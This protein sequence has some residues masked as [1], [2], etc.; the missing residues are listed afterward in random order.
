MN[1]FLSQ[2]S[3][4]VSAMRILIVEDNPTDRDLLKYL[5]E[6]RFQN[7]AKFREANNLETAFRYLDG[8]NI[9]CVILDLQLPDSTGKETFQRL[10]D[11][12]PDVPV[13]VMTHNKDRGLALDMIK[14][15]AAD[16]ILKDYT[17]EEDIFRRIIFAVEKHHRTIR[18]STEKASSL[19]ALERAKANMLSAHESGEH[20]AIQAST[21]ATTSAVADLS[22]HLFTEL[23]KLSGQLEAKN[24]RDET[25]SKTIESLQTELLGS[26]SQ[27]SVKSRIESLDHR[28]GIIEKARKYPQKIRLHQKTFGIVALIMVLSGTILFLAIRTHQEEPLRKDNTSERR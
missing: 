3:Y 23:Q 18:V 21:I 8:R 15:G 25:M 9:D 24:T 11:R 6:S 14:A 10:S 7:E 16:Y 1:K 26:G 5:L 19:H 17:N 27:L 2:G 20:V 28:V 4:E 22:R 13:I 12:Y